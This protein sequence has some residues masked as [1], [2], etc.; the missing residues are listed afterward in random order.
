MFQY[1]LW[2]ISFVTLWLTLIW[3]NFLYVQPKPSRN[4]RK[5]LVSICVPAYNEEKTI[6]KTLRSLVA[7]T[8]PNKEII[9]VDDGSQDKTVR[10]IRAF[11]KKHAVKVITQ[12]NAGKAAAVNAGLD[13]AKGELFGVVDADSRLDVRSLSRIVPHFSKEECGAVITHIRVDDPRN[14]LE[15]LQRV[16]YVM[17]NMFRKVMNNLGTLCITPGVLSVYRTAVLRKLGGFVRDGANLTEDFEIALRLKDAGYDIEMEPRATTYTK[18]PASFGSLWRQR[19]R[20]SRGFVYN[21]VNYKHLFFSRRHGFFG[22]FQVP[23]NVVGVLI[24]L[25]TVTLFTFDFFHSSLIFLSR[26][27]TIPDYFLTRL[28]S[29]PTLKEFL[30]AR[31]AHIALPIMI[32]FALGIYLITF[33][34]RLFK[35]SWKNQLGAIVGYMVLIPYFSAANWFA[36]VYHEVFN[37][38]RKW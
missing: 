23:V 25:F 21:H 18:V 17:S 10:V 15:R 7:L 6:L 35:E 3:L 12:K 5:P 22:M 24:L 37:T 32:S 30:L 31:D 14:M 33:A 28:T 11:A 34:L 1:I 20:W 19:I 4:A 26:S 2:G 9:V 16:E 8:Y 38:K 13:A 27:L 36:S 29:L